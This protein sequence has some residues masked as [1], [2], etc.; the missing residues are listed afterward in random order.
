MGNFPPLYDV[1]VNNQVNEWSQS[2]VRLLE[3][4]AKQFPD[5]Y[6]DLPT[7]KINFIPSGRPYGKQKFTFVVEDKVDL[8]NAVNVHVWLN[9]DE[10]LELISIIDVDKFNDKANALI[11]A[12]VR[13]LQTNLKWDTL[14]FYS[15]EDK[16]LRYRIGGNIT[17]APILDL[18][19]QSTVN[20]TRS[21]DYKPIKSGEK[22]PDF[23]IA[24]LKVLTTLK[25]EK[26][27]APNNTDKPNKYQLICSVDDC[28]FN[29][30]ENKIIII[31]KDGRL[32]DAIELIKCGI[33]PKKRLIKK[34]KTEKTKTESES[35][36]ALLDTVEIST[37]GKSP[38][39]VK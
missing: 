37:N 8:N 33:H 6:S 18:K 1:T 4:N 27:E 10:F 13:G 16:S 17:K 5:V 25:A 31:D 39:A 20:K 12:L 2:L 38:V 9:S 24:E 19:T 23:V 21:G 11:M 26:Y 3:W 22:L 15:P 32:E 14:R 30:M 28:K 35:V 7:L 34:T 36:D 29:H